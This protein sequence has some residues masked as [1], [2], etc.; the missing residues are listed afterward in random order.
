[1]YRLT[2]GDV[3][4]ENYRNYPRQI[5][6]VDGDV[7][8]TWTDLEARVNRLAD[9][10]TTRGIAAGDRVAWLG[11]NSF[12]ALELI[13]CCAKLGAVACLA[14]WRQAPAELAFVLA[15]CG[16]SLVVWQSE[17]VADRTIAARSLARLPAAVPWICHDDGEY[18]RLIESGRSADPAVLV[19]STSALLM[20]YTAAFDGRPSGALLSHEAILTQDLVLGIVAR[21]DSDFTYLNCGPLFHIATL[22]FTMATFHLAGR[23]VFVRRPDPAEIARLVDAERCNGGFLVEP[24]LSRMRESAAGRYDLG[25]LAFGSPWNERPHGY[26]QTETTGTVTLNSWGG[27]RLGNSGRPS[28]M[29]QVRIIDPGSGGE[30][31]AGVEGEIVVRGGQLMN[32]YH[33]RAGLNESRNL[34]GWHRTGDVGRR[35][36]DGSVTWI[37]TLSRIIRSGQENVYPAEVELCLRQLPDVIDAAVIGLPDPEWGQAVAAVVTLTPGSDTDAESVVT[38]CKS[39]IA[40]YKVPR[41]IYLGEVPYREGSIDYAALDAAYGGGGYPGEHAKHG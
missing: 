9:A 16:P 17:E 28:P 19:D 40:G 2:V 1:V 31:A 25:S 24:V 3:L 22:M 8:L 13:L 30:A 34:D 11:Q 32:G 14:N 38:Q 33:D 7:R 26:G 6:V 37:R 39:M 21:I 18:E 27:P 35:E 5:A 23:N 29:V 12:R 4:R 36:D 15:D 41:V 20:L 10:F